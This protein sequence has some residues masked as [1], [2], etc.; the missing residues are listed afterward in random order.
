MI[1]N[2]DIP[3]EMLASY[4]D[5]RTT[6]LEKGLI[7]DQLGDDNINDIIDIVKDAVSFSDMLQVESL[8]HNEVIYSYI[9]SIEQFNDLKSN[10]EDAETLW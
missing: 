6:P 3:D 8:E 4:I 5:G 7:E 9:R 1:D 2:F 10:P